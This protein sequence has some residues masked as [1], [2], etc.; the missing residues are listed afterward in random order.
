[1]IAQDARVSFAV[2]AGEPADSLAAGFRVGHWT[3]PDAVSGC[4]VVLL[5]PGNVCGYEVR[6]SAPGS[7]ELACL[8]LA[9]PR[10]EVHA[11]VLTGGSAYGLA[12][13]DGVMRWLEEQGVG[14][15]VGPAR[16]PIVPAAVVLDFAAL[17]AD[18]R[19]DAAAGRAACERAT[20]GPV[21]RGLVGA[22]TGA[23]VGKWVD[24][25]RRAPG[26][27]GI[28]RAAAAG[29]EVYAL[30]VVNAVGDV[31]APDGSVLA[32]SRTAP[33]PAGP[34]P[35]TPAPA[36]PEPGTPAPGGPPPGAAGLATPGAPPPMN[37]VLGVVT[38]RAV[39]SK[40]DAHFLAARGSDGIALSVRPAHTRYDGDIVFAVAAPPE[41]GRHTAAATLPAGLG[42]AGAGGAVDVDVL[43]VLATSAVA[44]AV[45]DAVM[46]AGRMG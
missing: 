1:M 45:R 11:V 23:T 41:P 40:Q 3:S 10:T 34:A 33:G 21:P 4:T 39:L 43:G 32:G 37:T 28:A 2:V 38:T 27:L 30:V 26:G 35:G 24:F 15:A 13:A 44:A 5:P 9:R 16:V 22:G 42:L 8:D 20:Q 6:G 14:Y 31:I 12:S 36:G 19:P 7:R 46:V 17:L 25:E 29:Y 18:Q